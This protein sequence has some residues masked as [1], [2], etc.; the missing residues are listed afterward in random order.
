MLNRIKQL[1]KLW[2]LTNKD[3][4]YLK[5]IETLTVDDIEKI[6]D[7]GNGGATFI[8]L[9]SESERDSYLKNQEPMWKKFNEKLREIIHD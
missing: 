6:P 2:T 5:A 3:P 4:R 8:P 1:K 9:M 7:K